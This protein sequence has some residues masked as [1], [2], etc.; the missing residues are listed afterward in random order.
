MRILLTTTSF[1]DT[2]GEHQ[3][4][5]KSLNYKIDILRGPLKEEILLPII[6]ILMLLV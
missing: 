5:L 1:T 4:K 2:P 3:E 6:M